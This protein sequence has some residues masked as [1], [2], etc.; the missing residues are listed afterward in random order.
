MRDS[1]TYV[2]MQ[3]PDTT[4][5]NLPF[6]LDTGVKILLPVI[7]TSASRQLGETLLYAEFCRGPA[8]T[9]ALIAVK[10][11]NDGNGVGRMYIDWNTGGVVCYE[12][13]TTNSEST[14]QS[15]I[16]GGACPSS[17]YSFLREFHGAVQRRE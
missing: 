1:V 11:N 13:D 6:P 2:L 4:F 9:N 10:V 16:R 15:I 14:Q 5:K 17:Y 7:C 3:S 8:N 12:E